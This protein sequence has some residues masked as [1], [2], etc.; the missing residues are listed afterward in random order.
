MP[1]KRKKNKLLSVIVPIFKKEKTIVEDL[2]QIEAALKKIPRDYDYEIIGVVDGTVDKSY[3]EAK[4]KG[5]IRIKIYGY[6]TNRGKGYAVRYGMA[7]AKGELVAFIDAGMEIDPLGI[8]MLMEHLA[9]YNADVI[10]GSKRHPVS[11]VDYPTQRKIVSFLYQLFVRFFTGLN[12]RDT[13]AG[14]KIY[15][16]QVLEKV[17]P[18]L[19]IKRY[20][21]DLEMLI[22][23]QHLGFKR[24][25]EAPIKIK[26]N[27]GD[28]T[29]AATLKEMKNALI[30][31]LGIIY[32][33]RFIHYYD[34]GNQ[35]K[36][37]YDKDLDMKVNV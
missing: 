19:I 13:Q 35:R 32:R 20:A 33:L 25:Y 31:T 3:Q 29:H 2:E 17:L 30:D 18:R 23:A 8:S 11:Q 14:L 27:L 5:S 9:W 21:F 34:E 16:R 22:V 37:I 6:K 12:V 4:K 7:R 10:I 26:F 1:F 24:I 36:W 15:R 28:A